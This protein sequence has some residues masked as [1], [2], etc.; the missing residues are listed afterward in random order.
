MPLARVRTGV[1]QFDDGWNVV[2]VIDGKTKVYDPTFATEEEAEAVAREVA[3][4][5]RKVLAENKDI[6]VL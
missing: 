5:F 3:A 2:T 4:N 1:A 6:T